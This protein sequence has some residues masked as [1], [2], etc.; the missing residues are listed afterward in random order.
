[1]YDVIDVAKYI[2]YFCKEHGFSISNLKLQKLLYFV[3]AQFL[4]YNG[5]PAFNEEIEAWDFGPVVP[6]AYQYF[7]IWGNSEI[8]N[9]IAQSADTKIYKKDQ[10]IIDEI[11]EEC[12]PYSA[13][14]LVEITHHQEP[15]TKVYQK[16]CNNVITKKSIQ[17]YFEED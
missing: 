9:V 12:A 3:Q 10:K 16:Y 13:S 1:M 6:E 11:L 4:V 7:K 5:K 17:K 2:V 8:P 14:V 15:W